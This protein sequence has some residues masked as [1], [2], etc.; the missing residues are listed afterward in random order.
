[1][2]CCVQTFDEMPVTMYG[3]ASDQWEGTDNWT[4]NATGKFWKEDLRDCLLHLTDPGGMAMW[5]SEEYT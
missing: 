5:K 3:E 1:M 4:E 2:V